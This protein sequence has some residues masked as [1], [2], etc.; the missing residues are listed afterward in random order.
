MPITEVLLWGECL[1]VFDV[2]PACVV[3]GSNAKGSIERAIAIKSVHHFRILSGRCPSPTVRVQ[4]SPEV[5]AAEHTVIVTIDEVFAKKAFA[6]ELEMTLQT[7]DGLERKEEHAIRIPLYRF[8]FH[9]E[10]YK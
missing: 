9:E 5:E 2:D 3:I 1:P 10:S 7:A 6:S 8:A 4:Y